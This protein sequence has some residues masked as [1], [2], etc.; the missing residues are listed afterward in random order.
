[1]T[2]FGKGLFHGIVISITILL[3]RGIVIPIGIDYIFHTKTHYFIFSLN[4]FFKKK[5]Q[6][7]EEEKIFKVVGR[8]PIDRTTPGSLVGGRP[9]FFF[10]LV[11]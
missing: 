9:P 11:I 3:Q 6:K 8:P 2:L 7:K 10:C 1:M 4:F 5:K